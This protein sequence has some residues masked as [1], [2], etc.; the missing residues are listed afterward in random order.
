MSL[1]SYLFGRLAAKGRESSESGICGTGITHGQHQWRRILLTITKYGRD[2]CS[3][4]ATPT[5]LSDYSRKQIAL[6]TSP[7][8]NLAH[9]S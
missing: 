2:R 6:G 8:G 4:C 5:V 7:T 1:K 3:W 9:S